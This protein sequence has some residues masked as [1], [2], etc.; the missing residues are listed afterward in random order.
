MRT[1]HYS[2]QNPMGSLQSGVSA[3]MMESTSFSSP[4]R[5]LE[6]PTSDVAGDHN[7][8]GQ[9]LASANWHCN[10]NLARAPSRAWIPQKLPNNVT[11]GHS[12]YHRDT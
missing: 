5:G 1:S 8:V 3:V 6:N 2:G 9:V 10:A 7:L 4:R 11:D 12:V